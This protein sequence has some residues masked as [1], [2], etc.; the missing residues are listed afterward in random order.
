MA[1]SPLKS[2]L[3][4]LSF[5]PITLCS[6]ASPAPAVAVGNISHVEYA[7]YFH[8]YYGQSFKV[9]KNAIDAKSY[10]LIQNT[11]RMAGRAKYCTSRIKSFIVP[12]SN[13]SVDTSAFPL[14]FLELLGQ[15]GS[16]KA[17]TSNSV[18]SECILKYN[19]EG[20]IQVV[21]ANET[22]LLSQFPAHFVSKPGDE[23]ACNFALFLPAVENTPVQRA[24]WIKYL[25]A[26]YNMEARANSIFTAV[27]ENYACLST[28]ASNRTT[29]PK[30]I[31]A[32]LQFNEGIWSF[33]K[34]A[35]K[36]E[37]VEAAGGEN[38]DSSIS[39]NTYNVSDPDDN[40]EFHAILCT[41]DVVIDETYVPEPETYK[42]SNFL[43]NVNIEDHSCFAF[44]SNQSLWRYDKRIIN[45]ST[46]DWYDGAISQPQLVLADLIEAFFPTGNY[47]TTY[48]RNIAKEEGIVNVVPEMCER[49]ASTAMQPTLV[50]CNGSY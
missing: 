37:Y 20:S 38:L 45:S 46:L 4:L 24:E 42:V 19:L 36:L 16:L 33:S 14:S 43:A 40:E 12:L 44:L 27:K 10:L 6:G 8:S 41:L 30:P 39:K 31:A 7:Q 11:S 18:S 26:F 50:R 3:L 29:S 49:D 32:W 48:F 2:F 34:D 21:N 13:F 25:G 23:L 1:F 28:A 35:Y 15:L 9:I 5:S 22:Q 17:I 47:N